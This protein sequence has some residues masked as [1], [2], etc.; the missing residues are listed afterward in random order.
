MTQ[1]VEQKR[2]VKIGAYTVTGKIGQGGIAEIYKARQESLNRDVAIKILFPKYSGDPDILRRF[3]RESVVIARLSHPNIVH[4]I[5]KGRAGNRYYFVMEYIDGTSLRE[6]IDSPS[7]SNKTALEMVA[8]VC[9][10]MSQF[11]SR[12]ADTREA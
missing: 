4:V 9:T 5:D 12:T 7:I 1:V 10:R 2:D 8:Q 3:E 11:A 6:V